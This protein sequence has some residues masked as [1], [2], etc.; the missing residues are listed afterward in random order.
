MDITHNGKVPQLG[1]DF[2]PSFSRKIPLSVCNSNMTWFVAHIGETPY[3]SWMQLL[4]GLH[5]THVRDLVQWRI[6]T[7]LDPSLRGTRRGKERAREGSEIDVQIRW[8]PPVFLPRNDRE[9]AS[10]GSALN[11]GEK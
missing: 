9:K 11:K 5:V 8:N 6:G 4:F 2:L 7:F 3:A 1:Q 10:F